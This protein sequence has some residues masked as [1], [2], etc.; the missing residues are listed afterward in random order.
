MSG[1]TRLGAV[2]YLNARPLV[3]ELD[4]DPLFSVR[5]D[6]P[7]RCAELL[8]AGDTDLGLIPAFEHGRLQYVAVPHVAIASDGPVESVAI[9]TKKPMR[10]VRRLALDTSSRTSANLVRLLCAAW[11]KIQPE[12]V[13]AAPDLSVMLEQA[14]AAL[15]IGD[16]GLFIDPAAF[17]VTKIDLGATWKEMTGLPFVWACWSGRPGAASPEVCRRLRETR[18]RGTAAVDRIGELHAPH[19]AARAA[20]VARYLREAIQYDLSG[21]YVRGLQTYYEMLAAYHLLPHNPE[22][23]FFAEQAARDVSSDSAS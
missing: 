3:Y 5:F 18:D 13:P 7:S 20:F 1:A 23:K 6:I 10:D 2:S 15:V 21:G 17:G 8:E 19:D 14:D 9:F 22:L 12:F 16:P 11:Y 4:R